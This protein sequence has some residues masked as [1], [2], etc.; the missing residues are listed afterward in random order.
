MIQVHPAKQRFSAKSDWL[1]SHFSFSFGPYYDEDNIQFGPLRVLNDDI[2]QPG[3]GFGIHPH[4]EAE[5][6]SIVLKG[7]LKHEDSLKNVGIIKF[8]NIQRMTAGTG[9]LHSE[10]NPT[11][12]EETHILQLWF[13]P[14]QKQ[15]APFYQ[16]IS[17]DAD[18][19]QNKL[20]PVVSGSPA[21]NAA[22]I[23][24][25]VTLYLS[26]LDGQKELRFEQP[27][28][29][30]IYLFVI[31]GEVLLNGDVSLKRRDD[32]RITDLPKLTIEAKQD[33]FFLLI[34]LPGGEE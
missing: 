17:F 33:A 22:S 21:V 5:I 29:R 30:K 13:H 2:I 9:V 20:L 19:L 1:E 18:Q 28:G 26:K 14:S 34:D 8:G 7:Q 11:D 4:R 12:D 27:A 10:V 25:D 32:A 24:Q 3:K 15:L 23:H 31:E 6:V 16:D